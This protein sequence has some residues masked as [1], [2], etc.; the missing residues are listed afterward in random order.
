MVFHSVSD[1][2][3][4]SKSLGVGSGLKESFDENDTP[5]LELFRNCSCGSTLMDFFSDRRDGSEQGR[6][7]REIFSKVLQLLEKKGLPREE[8]RIELQKI[9]R[10][11]RSEIIEEFGIGLKNI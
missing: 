4:Y 1:F 7:R 2:I 11:E 8:A 5:I 3:D 6:K 9:L 10:G